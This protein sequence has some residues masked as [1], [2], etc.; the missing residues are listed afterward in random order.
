MLGE[1]RDLETASIAINASL[2]GHLVFST[3]H[4]NS[5]TAAVA[6]LI[7]IGVKPFLIASATRCLM[8][9]RLVRKICTKCEGPTDPDTSEL[10]ALGLDI[11]NIKD[12][13]FKIGKGCSKCNNTGY[14]GRFGLFEVYVMEDEGRK[15]VIN[16]ETSGVIQNHARKVGMRTLREDG[17]RKAIAGMTTPKE[18]LRVTVGD[19]N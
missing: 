9:Q 10:G 5:A 13:N 4:T 16:K 19:E 18:V 17:A 6:R 8:A 15:L 3:L 12:P 11:N 7:D 14:K 2:T 1:I